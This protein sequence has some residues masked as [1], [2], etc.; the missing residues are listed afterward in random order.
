MKK[1]KK[2][3]LWSIEHEDFA[4]TSYLFGTVHLRATKV[5]GFLEAG[6]EKLE[7]CQAVATEFNLDEAK[8]QSTANALDLPEDYDLQEY[9][10]KKGFE[11]L[12]K[13]FLRQ[14]GMPLDSFSSMHPFVL[15]SL[16][17][18]AILPDEL[19][20]SLDETIWHVGKEM[21][22]VPYGLESYESQIALIQKMP[23]K[24][25]VKQLKDV[26]R[27]FKKFKKSQHKLMSLYADGELQRLNKMALKQAKGFRKVMVYNRNRDMVDRF[28]EIAKK[29]TLFAA[30]GAG[31]LPGQK[32]MLRELKKRGC[33]IKGLRN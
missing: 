19:R 1:S 16:L 2:T 4:G 11:K 7:E 30:V 13:I 25:Q 18:Q 27:N 26:V 10:G 29:E 3:W 9:I 22:K 15:T 14:T 20:M 24:K 23:L 5:F 31:H 21:K 8:D 28:L 17:T 12:A 32:G 33:K 6:L